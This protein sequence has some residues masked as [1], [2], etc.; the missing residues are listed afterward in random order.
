MARLYFSLLALKSRQNL[1]GCHFNDAATF[2]LDSLYPLLPIPTYWPSPELSTFCANTFLCL[3]FFL[4]FLLFSW[5]LSI[6]RETKGEKEKRAGNLNSALS[7][8][9]VW[10]LITFLTFALHIRL[11]S[12]CL[13]KLDTH[14]PCKWA[15]LILSG[16]PE[17]MWYRP[18]SLYP[19]QLCINR[20]FSYT[21]F[22]CSLQ[23]LC[24]LTLP[25]VVIIL[26]LVPVLWT[27]SI[28]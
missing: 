28:T 23:T 26:S 4:C 5:I 24:R 9:S 13:I 19:K 21:S 16:R 12:H 10:L 17:I 8:L 11:S 27:L 1:T 22:T 14:F 7:I 3:T 20:V 2:I 18:T 25:P 6:F 15:C